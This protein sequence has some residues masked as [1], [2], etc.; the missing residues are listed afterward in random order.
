MPLFTYEEVPAY[1]QEAQARMERHRRSWKRKHGDVPV[2]DGLDILDLLPQPESSFD[3][4]HQMKRPTLVADAEAWHAQQQAGVAAVRPLCG[5]SLLQY[6]YTLLDAHFEPH[7]RHGKQLEYAQLTQ[8]GGSP[9]LYLDK[10]RQLEK[11]IGSAYPREAI[12][13]RYIKGLDSKIRSRVLAKYE[14]YQRDQWYAKLDA[15]ASDAETIWLNQQQD[16]ADQ[17][18]AKSAKDERAATQPAQ[19]SAPARGNS[20]ASQ[21]SS[22]GGFLCE[23]HGVNATHNTADCKVLNWQ[24]SKTSTGK[25][26]GGGGRRAQRRPGRPARG[27]PAGAAGRLL[28]RARD[29]GRGADSAARQPDI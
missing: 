1:K 2:E 21:P 27:L 4:W 22:K 12:A 14:L 16:K 18:L 23:H 26:G 11:Y 3:T 15:I 9:R 13:E 29:A 8:A 5:E 25:Q 19:P 6:Y 20:Q 10:V 24:Q 7:K 28:G 17:Q